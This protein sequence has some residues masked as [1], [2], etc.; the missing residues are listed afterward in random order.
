MM[1]T[2]QYQT[3]KI[4]VTP[5]KIFLTFHAILAK[6]KMALAAVIRL[7]SIVGMVIASATNITGP[8]FYFWIQ[9]A[10]IDLLK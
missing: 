10:R 9:F 1:R 8:S 7:N 6:V 4:F 2:T 3:L 5:P